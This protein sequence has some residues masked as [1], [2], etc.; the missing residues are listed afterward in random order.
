MPKMRGERLAEMKALLE[1]RFNRGL[2][3]IGE[4]K[5]QTREKDES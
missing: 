1:L 5:L 3:K 4:G 2:R